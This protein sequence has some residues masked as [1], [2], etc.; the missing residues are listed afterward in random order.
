LFLEQYRLEANPFAADRVR[1]FFV[2]HSSQ[3]AAAKIA[4]L[5]ADQIQI[6][7]L[8]GP[9]HVG[10]TTLVYRY[11]RTL[12]NVNV[13]WIEPGIDHERLLHK[14]V[15]DLGPGAVEGPPGE[16]RN[17]LQVYL[18]H[19]AGS[20]RRSLIVADGIERQS[21][22]VLD[23]LEALSR[24]RLRHRGVVQMILLARNSELVESF[25]THVDGTPLPRATHQRFNGFT[26]QETRA[27][28]RGSLQNAGCSWFD[29]LLPEESLVDIQ[30]FT[31]G[32]VGDIDA[33]LRHALEQ[34]A[35]R[36]RHA[37]AQ[38]TVTPGL[39]RDV[40]AKL[41]LKYEPAAW[42]LPQ[43][44]ALSSEAVH[45]KETTQLQIEAARLLVTSG[46]RKVAEISLSR[47]RMV[48]GRDRSCD[49]SLD[50]TFVSRYQ[51]LFMETPEGWVLID[52]NSTNGCFVNGR[53]V[54]EHHLRDG[55]LIAVG[56]HELRFTGP[57]TVAA[58]SVESTQSARAAY[59]I[60]M[61]A[62][63]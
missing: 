14:L 4:A 20:G 19:Q 40:A 42:K 7:A 33:L 38:P 44:K 3:Y 46:G 51:N 2:S 37:I 34:L 25:V 15:R 56:Q 1:P 10:K 24:M 30:A 41:H 23:E 27:Y 36:S 13:S 8:S 12:K 45:L 32:V 49:I 11:L 58:A 22:E 28:L 48:L 35:V 43:E 59:E 63:G 57:T 9:A 50:S 60:L 29:E 16:L 21:A 31:Q 47:P 52:L 54:S 39:L 55:D 26:L 6:L 61:S 62:P 18:R 17:I 5:F 53:R